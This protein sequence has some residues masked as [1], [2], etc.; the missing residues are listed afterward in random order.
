MTVNLFLF[1]SFILQIFLTW[2]TYSLHFFLSS[3]YA[4]LNCPLVC[5][6]ICIFRSLLD[7]YCQYL[8]QD[9]SFRLNFLL[10]LLLKWHT[11]E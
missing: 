10:D 9:V 8:H 4:E 11:Q 5:Q 7:A 1:V 3:W 2:H 6:A